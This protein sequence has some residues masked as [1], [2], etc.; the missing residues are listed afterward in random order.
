MAKG[1]G[2]PKTQKVSKRQKAYLKLIEKL[3]SCRSG[4]EQKVLMDNQHLID[5]G[6][7]KAMRIMAMKF[8]EEGERKS[9]S[10]LM[11][12]AEYLSKEL[13]LS[14]DFLNSS[15]A[16]KNMSEM[17]ETKYFRNFLSQIML[18]METRNT[19]PEAT[20][21]ILQT[22]LQ[23]DPDFIQKFRSWVMAKIS[24]ATPKDAIGYASIITTFGNEISGFPLGETADNLEETIACFE[25][26]LS[27]VDGN[28]LPDSKML[29]PIIIDLLAIAYC[30]RIKGDKAENLELGITKLEEAL[31]L[32]T[33]E[34]ETELWGQINNSLGIAYQDRIWGDQTENL[35][36]AIAY[37]KNALQ[38]RH[39]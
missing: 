36:L 39:S 10:F 13:E 18:A 38:V 11:G 25:V 34:T 15:G 30:E 37:S 8:A 26:A 5:A 20:H 23:Q 14:N 27:V 7:V 19:N 17:E 9:A 24:E 28:E 35:E 6:L 1:F 2:K 33:R 32:I 31:K 3:L 16:T 4:I 12:I 29:K 21:P 22:Y